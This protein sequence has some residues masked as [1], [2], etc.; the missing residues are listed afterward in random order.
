MTKRDTTID[1]DIRHVA[2]VLALRR[3]QRNGWLE[4]RS[5]QDMA[6][7]LDVHRSTVMRNLRDL[8]EV[9]RLADEYT[10]R[11]APHIKTTG[12]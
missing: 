2:R 9:E 3:A 7:Q 4:G 6:D 10:S 12:A 11:L 5:L 8:E 1:K